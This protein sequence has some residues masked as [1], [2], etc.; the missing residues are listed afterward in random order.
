MWFPN[1][2][3]LTENSLKS[4]PVV[5][6]DE[7][8][9][10]EDK[11]KG[12]NG[13]YDAVVNAAYAFH[14]E[15]EPFKL[16]PPLTEEPEA[17]LIPEEKLIDADEEN[18]K[19]LLGIIDEFAE[20]G[21]SLDLSISNFD[22]KYPIMAYPIFPDPTSFYLR[23]LSERFILPSVDKLKM[24]SISC[25]VTNPIFEEA[26]LA[27]MNTEMG[28]ELL[29]RE[30][31]T[32]ERGSYFRKFWDQVELPR[33]FGKGYFDV[34]Y[35]HNWTRPLGANHEEGKGQLLVF[36]IKSELMMQYP[37]TGITLSRLENGQL[38]PFLGPTMTGW[39]SDDTYMAGFDI[40]SLS[41]NDKK[42]VYLAFTETDKS[43]RFSQ[44]PIKRM[45]AD[46][47]NTSSLF[48]VNRKNDGS[49]WGI[50]V[51]PGDL[52][53]NTLHF[54]DEVLDGDD[55]GSQWLDGHLNPKPNP[56]LGHNDPEL[57]IE[58]HFRS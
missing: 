3:D 16:V 4:I 29:W 8:G 47:E 27:G 30:Y 55:S 54:E 51:A 45:S 58:P 38:T 5:T 57:N 41:D 9:L 53:V 24:N 2:V 48:A 13:Y 49:V 14:N 18:R 19:R 26:F 36:V 1:R 17:E 32:D 12:M 52:V 10:V 7:I 28:R 46:E 33:D 21:M 22:G 34:K 31:P 6:A 42:G 20:R 44:S 23:E 11:I 56:D 35:L 39:L 25:F 43:Q 37:Q 50:G 15:L 40:S